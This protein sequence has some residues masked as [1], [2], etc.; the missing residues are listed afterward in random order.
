MK[1]NIFLHNSILVL[2]WT[3][4]L[5]PKEAMVDDQVKACD[6]EKIFVLLLRNLNLCQIDIHFFQ[7]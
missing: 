6:T 7:F 3:F 1:N 4:S 2:G 5:T